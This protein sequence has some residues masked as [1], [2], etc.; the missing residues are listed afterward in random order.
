MIDQEKQIRDL[1]QQV[2]DENAASNLFN[3]SP[4]AFHTHNGVDSP[5]LGHL[6]LA[7]GGY[8]NSGKTSFT[9]S[10][11][12]GFWLG[13]E[14]LFVGSALDAN[15]LKF[16]SSTGLLEYAGNVSGRASSVLASAID[17]S[18]HF[19]D[20]NLNTSA[21][22]I[23]G[24][25]NFDSTDYSG[26]LK[27]GNITWNAATGAITGGSGGLFNKNGLVFASNGVATITLDGATGSATFAGTLSGASGTF[28]TITAGNISGVT[29]TGSTLSTGTTGNTDDI[30]HGRI[31]PR[32]NTPA[33]VYSDVGTYGGWWGLKDIDGHSVFYTDV[34]SATGN[35][36]DIGFRGDSTYS[37]DWYFQCNHD[38]IFVMPSSRYVRPSAD[39]TINLGNNSYRWADIRTVLINGNTPLAGTKTYYVANTS[40]GAVNRKLTFSDGI[41]ISET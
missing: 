41:L 20:T 17:S 38:I 25:F 22:T 31:R 18:G 27:T 34:E 2:I 39:N 35:A 14:G 33:V 32:Y 1:I 5:I 29:I 26:A 37:Y 3:V 28:G 12:N 16:N 36:H 23:L 8:V 19:I 11:H 30:K 24:S 9:D 7:N 4:I 40:G 15:K 10:S 6:T 13:V 21:K